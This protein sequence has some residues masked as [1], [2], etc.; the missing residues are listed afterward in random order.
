MRG[1]A[2]TTIADAQTVLRAVAK[3]QSLSLDARAI[4]IGQ[5]DPAG[6]TLDVVFTADSVIP[7]A[8][9]DTATVVANRAASDSA[10]SQRFPGVAF[11]D[12][13]FLQLT[14]PPDAIDFWKA[15]DIVYDDKVG[16]TSSFANQEGVYL[17]KAD[18]GPRAAAWTPD[19]TPPLNDKKNGKSGPLLSDSTINFLAWALAG[20]ALAWLGGHLF[21]SREQHP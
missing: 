4:V 10:L 16:P 9:P 18:D 13:Q 6:A 2:I 15:H 7:Y 17:G 3:A 12:P 5:A 21:F 8:V 19:P 14:A 20:S 11:V 1:A